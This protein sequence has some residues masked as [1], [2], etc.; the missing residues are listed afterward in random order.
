MVFGLWMGVRLFVTKR[1]TD[2]L[3]SCMHGHKMLACATAEHGM[4][5][6]NAHILLQLQVSERK[7]HV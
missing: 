3:K 1:F 2:N 5:R 4:K 6:S 7:G